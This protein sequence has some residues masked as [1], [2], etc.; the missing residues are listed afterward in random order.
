MAAGGSLRTAL[1]VVG[2]EPA[3]PSLDVPPVAAQLVALLELQ[4]SV[5]VCPESDRVIERLTVTTG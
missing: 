5:A 4:V 3:Q 1:P 2:F